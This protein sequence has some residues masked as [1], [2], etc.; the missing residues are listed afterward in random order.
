M[1]SFSFLFFFFGCLTAHGVPRPGIRPEPRSWPR[2]HLQQHQ[3]LNPL[4]W[5]GDQTRIPGLPSCHQ[6]WCTTVGTPCFPF[7]MKTYYSY[8]QNLEFSWLTKK[9]LKKKCLYHP[10][11][12]KLQGKKRIFKNLIFLT[13]HTTDAPLPVCVLPSHGMLIGVPGLLCVYGV[14]PCTAVKSSR[15]CI[16][17]KSSDLQRNIN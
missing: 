3:I 5:A 14:V 8:N 1:L 4:C 11:P 9:E 17:K 16:T 12:I 7:Q 6:S 15:A 13:L 2:L 10:L